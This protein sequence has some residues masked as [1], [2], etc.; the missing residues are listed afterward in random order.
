MVKGSACTRRDRGEVDPS[1]PSLTGG[2]LASRSAGAMLLPM[3]TCCAAS[4]ALLAPPIASRPAAA[5]PALTARPRTLHPQLTAAAAP[6]PPPAATDL[7]T[8]PPAPP[9]AFPAWLLVTV[10]F[11]HVLA[12]AVI[13]QAL[14][15][16]LLSGLGN[17]R[18][19]TARLLG[20]LSSLAALLDIVVTPQLG[21]L[22]DTIGRRPLLLAAPCVTLVVRCLAAARPQVAVLILVKLLS[23]TVSSTYM[24]SLR[25][26][27]ADT[28]KCDAQIKS[29]QD[30]AILLR[31]FLTRLASFSQV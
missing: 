3:I 1:L 15:T 5:A 21:R 7:R 11:M 6:P 26:A 13:A 17:D 31:K 12:N 18:V 30:G 20:R 29:A 8:P 2:E 27:V 4:L 22:S 14:P 24:V 16:A 9:P 25:A 28:F 23:A 10:V 19:R